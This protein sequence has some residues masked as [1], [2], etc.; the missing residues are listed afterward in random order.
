MVKKL[1]T[2]PAIV[3][4]GLW[5]LKTL[6]LLKKDYRDVNAKLIVLITD[7]PPAFMIRIMEG[8]FW[9]EILD[10]VI[11][12]KDLDGVKSDGYISLPSS[13]FLG[14]VDGVLEGIKKG[15]VLVNGDAI[16]YLIKIG[17]AV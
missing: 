17:A 4:S 9:V 6:G 10:D 8:D 12:V 7:V 16:K 13:V 15:T 3:Y 1:S 14:G 11:S 5:V 2:F